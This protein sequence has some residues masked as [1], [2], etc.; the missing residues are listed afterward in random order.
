[1]LIGDIPKRNAK[2]YPNE[3]ALK[4]EEREYTFA[5][6]NERVNRLANALFRFRIRKGDRI[7]VLE[8]NCPEYLELYFGAAKCGNV[9]VPINPRLSQEEILFL[10]K[11]SGARV[12]FLGEEFVDI[13]R[14]VYDQVGELENLVLFHRARF[15]NSHNYEEELAASPSDEPRVEV[16]DND[17]FSILYTSG[18]TGRP[19]GVMA[20]HRNTMANTINMTLELNIQK[21]DVTLLVMPLYHNGGVWPTLVHFYRGARIILHRRFNE[22]LALSTIENERITTF[23]LVPIMLMRLLDYPD[24]QKYTCGSLRLIFYGGAPMPIPLL[25]RALRTFGN[26]LMTGLGLT[27][28]NGGILFLH[29]EE[30]ILEGPEEEVSRLASVGRDAMNV[31]TRI[32]ND[33]GKEVKPGEVGEIIVKGENVMRG[34][35]N[36]PEETTNAVRGGWLYTGDLATVDDNSYVYVKDRAKDIVISGGENISS[37]EV[38]DAIY[39]HPDISEVA[40]IGIPDEKWGEAIHAIIVPKKGSTVTEKDVIDHCKKSLASFKKPR[41]IEFVD[42]LPR[43]ILGKVRKDELRKKFW[44][45]SPK[46]VH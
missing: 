21:N 8:R 45:T 17:L 27:E 35:W 28:A 33:Q 10:L 39:T 15:P 20:S 9:V 19:K 38:E 4:Y 23:N 46:Q 11:D 1:M 25:K 42:E 3:I 18:T 43:N 41:S 31:T 22:R 16:T 37:K 7:A 2:L 12:L 6:F 26:R 24:R 29:P 14:F 36:L 30:L 32:I 5:Y 34:Y 40:V 13:G 44:E